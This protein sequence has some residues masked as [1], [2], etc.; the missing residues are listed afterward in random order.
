MIYLITFVFLKPE[1]FSKSIMKKLFIL[2]VVVL[3]ACNPAKKTESTESE[4]V[5]VYSQRHYDVDKVVFDKFTEATGITVNVVQAGADELITRMEQEGANSP[6]D[7]F[8][9]VD[10]ARLNRAKQL[11]LLQTAETTANP[12]FS[13]PEKFWHGI[14][15]RARVIAY[16]KEKVNPADLSTYEDLA[17]EKWAGKILVRSSTNGYNQ[18]LLASI[19][20]AS[21]EA[22]AE[23]WAKGVVNNMAR[24]PEGGD[25]DQVKA[26]AA[27]VGEIAITNTYYVGLLLNSPNPEEVKVGESVGIFFP[28]QEGRGTHVNVSGIGV[29]KNSPNKDN[30]LAFIEFLLTD[31]IQRLYADESFE[32]PTS[33]TVQAHP[34]VAAWG[35]FKPDG[36]GFATDKSYTDQAVLIFDR[37]GW[38]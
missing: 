16:D 23:A 13:D 5:N 38:K 20:Y 32:Y 22:T 4:V 21:D 31:D 24:E 29:T 11:G 26:I 10:A 37:A 6:A 35:T 33:P 12:T 3:S 2:L 36:L 9:T 14:T 25:R 28:N 34:S 30:A 17:N 7:L 18:S 1:S 8:F 19:L 27:G 15:Y